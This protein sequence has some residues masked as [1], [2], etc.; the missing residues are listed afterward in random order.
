M[1]GLFKDYFLSLAEFEIKYVF[2]VAIN[3]S[4]SDLVN[5]LLKLFP[6]LKLDCYYKPNISLIDFAISR[7]IHENV[8]LNLQL[9]NMNMI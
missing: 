6:K 3:Y 5:D 1:R 2:N 8:I 7:N 4:N 9:L